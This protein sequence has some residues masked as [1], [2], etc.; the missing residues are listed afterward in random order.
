MVC[1]RELWEVRERESGAAS[2]RH[3]ILRLIWVIKSC[4]RP[5]HPRFRP[6]FS[7]EQINYRG[8]ERESW[9][10]KRWGR[11]VLRRWSEEEG[12]WLLRDASSWP[13]RWSWTSQGWVINQPHDCSNKSWIFFLFWQ[14]NAQSI[15]TSSPEGS[16]VNIFRYSRQL[17]RLHRIKNDFYDF[18]LVD[19]RFTTLFFRFFFHFES[20]T[21]D[22]EKCIFVFPCIHYLQHGREPDMNCSCVQAEKIAHFSFRR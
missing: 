22:E 9:E 1:C 17:S 4:D 11:R 20:E 13:T 2:S 16:S 18:C 19:L 15:S 12:S 7:H 14:F 21:E 3:G 6:Q 10:V 8:Q 5:S